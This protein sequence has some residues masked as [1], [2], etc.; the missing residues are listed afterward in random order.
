MNGGDRFYTDFKGKNIDRTA[1]KDG[2]GNVQGNEYDLAKDG[3]FKGKTIAVLHL[4]TGKSTGHIPFDFLLPEKALQ[5]KGFTVV[6]WQDTLPALEEFKKT[7]AKSTQLWIIST[8]NQLLNNAYLSVIKDFFNQ[9]RGLFLWGDNNPYYKDAN[10]V[11]QNLFNTTMSGDTMG[12]KVVSLQKEESIIGIMPNHAITTG[13]EFLYEGITI[14]TI[15]ANKDFN[16]LM[17]GS[18]GNLVTACYEKNGKRAIIDGG[19]TRLYNKWDTA[20]TA[21]FVKNA[22]A[23]LANV[24]RFDLQ[25]QFIQKNQSANN[26]I[27]ADSIISKFDKPNNSQKSK[28]TLPDI[29]STLDKF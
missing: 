27:Q 22:A 5:E 8:D 1:Q 23:W 7:L 4:Y 2:Y 20:G 9:G 6:R 15:S 13:L 29:S 3:A 10:F 11:S 19:F 25:N 26:A 12:D 18:A 17:Y 28:N 14:A 21:R 16:P 24:E